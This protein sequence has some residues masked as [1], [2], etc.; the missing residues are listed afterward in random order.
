MKRSYSTEQA[1]FLKAYIPGH[2][3]SETAEAFNRRFPNTPVTA[4]KIQ[5]WAKRHGVRSGRKGMKVRQNGSR[6]MMNICAG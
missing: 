3:Y 1:D 4:D 6:H 5:A 2:H